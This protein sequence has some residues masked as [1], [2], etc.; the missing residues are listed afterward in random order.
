[1]RFLRLLFNNKRLYKISFPVAYH[2]QQVL[3]FFEAIKYKTVIHVELRRTLIEIT[4]LQC[5][6][7]PDKYLLSL[8]ALR[9]KDAE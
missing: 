5:P 8:V 4:T 2:L 1:M 3:F 6:D 7:G 9:S